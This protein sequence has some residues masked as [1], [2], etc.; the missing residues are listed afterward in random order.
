MKAKSRV[1]LRART[2][3]Q[4]IGGRGTITVATPGSA[5][6]H[7][8]VSGPPRLRRI[9]GS[10]KAERQTITVGYTAGLDVYAFS[11]G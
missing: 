9:H 3:Y 8:R 7:I 2:A 6:R 11:F 10:A 4:L 5:D 1:S